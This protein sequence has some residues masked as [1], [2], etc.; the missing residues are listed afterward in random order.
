MFTGVIRQIAHVISFKG[1]LL[2]LRSSY[3]PH[4][5]DSICINGAC[6][7]VVNT[8]DDIF[9]VQLSYES[10]NIL[11]INNYKKEKIHIEPAMKMQ[12]RFEGHVVQGHVDCVGEILSIIENGVNSTDYNIKVPKEYIKYIIPK[13]SIAINGISLTINDVKDDTFRLTIIPYS[14]KNTLFST[15]KIGD[16]VNIETDMFARYIYHM[17]N[18]KD[19]KSSWEDI[20]RKMFTY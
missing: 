16:K 5:G 19:D 13:G 18:K 3:R 4:L 17:F 10:Q 1:D 6:L 2:T 15:Y 20:D 14:L 9:S 8:I 7:T 12:D 11:A